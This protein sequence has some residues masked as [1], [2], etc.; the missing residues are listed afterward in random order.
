M[1]SFARAVRMALRFRF[2]LLA[3]FVCSLLVGALW[4]ANIGTLYPFVEIVFQGE[5]LQHSVARKLDDAQPAP[6][7][8]RC[9]LCAAD[10]RAVRGRRDPQGR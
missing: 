7:A 6:G 9:A 2:T 3:A 4:G 1:R 5:S 10:A 8:E